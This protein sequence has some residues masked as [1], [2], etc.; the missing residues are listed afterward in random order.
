MVQ[1]FLSRAAEDTLRHEFFDSEPHAMAP[2]RPPNQTLQARLDGL[3]GNH[4]HARGISRDVVTAR[5]AIPHLFVNY[6]L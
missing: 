2:A 6:L 4:F 5:G 1:D 3:T